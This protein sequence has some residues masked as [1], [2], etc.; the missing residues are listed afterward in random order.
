MSDGAHQ[1]AERPRSKARAQHEAA[2]AALQARGDAL[3]DALCAT[4]AELAGATQRLDELKTNVWQ[5]E[6]AQNAQVVEERRCWQ[7]EVHACKEQMQALQVQL[8]SQRE[9]TEEQGRALEERRRRS[10]LASSSGTTAP[11]DTRTEG[12]VDAAAKAGVHA[13]FK[14]IDGIGVVGIV[15]VSRPCSAYRPCPGRR[16]A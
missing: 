16:E 4:Q 3:R 7:A 11:E 12:A 10:P 15:R 5:R 6:V 13:A 2:E 14:V 9:G 8:T 1:Q